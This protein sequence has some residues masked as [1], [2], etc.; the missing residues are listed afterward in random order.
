M[1]AARPPLVIWG[2]AGHALVVADI[3]RLR[4]E[5]TIAGFLEDGAP[6][7]RELAGARVLGGRERLA[8]LR[9]QGVAHL[10][11]GFGDCERRLEAAELA[12]R[13]GF[14]FATAVHPRAIVAGDVSVG[15]GTVVAA[16]AVINPAARVGAHVI[17]NTSSSVDHECVIE[18]GAHVCPGAHLAAHVVVGR[19]AWVGVGAAVRD[20]VRIGA[21]AVIGAGAAVVSD[22]P[23]HM[24]AYGVP[25]RVVRPV[26]S[27]LASAAGRGRG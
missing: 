13:A 6:A 20:R 17:V 10:I 19:G 26:D 21:G 11:V 12:R 14:A 9:A 15:E 23:D 25:A 2:A 5:Y 18:D 22:I 27:D 1:T 7:G 16:G 8:D 4:G 3:V 24:V